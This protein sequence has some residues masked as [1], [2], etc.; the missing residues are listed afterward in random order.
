MAP[1]VPRILRLG[2]ERTAA[3][4][5]RFAPMHVVSGGRHHFGWFEIGGDAWTVGLAEAGA[6]ADAGVPADEVRHETRRL[7]ARLR[8]DRDAGESDAPPPVGPVDDPFRMA[9]D[10]RAALARLED[11]F[12]RI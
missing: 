11:E 3:D 2:E 12:G 4:G 6:V 7:I 1:T 5:R 10:R 8:R 9:E